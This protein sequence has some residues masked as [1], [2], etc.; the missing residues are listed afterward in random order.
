M[1]SCQPHIDPRPEKEVSET[2]GMSPICREPCLPA[3]KSTL[4]LVVL[5]CT[6]VFLFCT[7]VFYVLYIFFL[8]C[9]FV[10]L[11]CTFSFCFVHFLSVLYIFFLFCTICLYVLYIFFLFC[12]FAV[13]FCIFV[14]LFCTFVSSDLP[15]FFCQVTCSDLFFFRLVTLFNAW[16]QFWFWT[17]WMCDSNPKIKIFDHLIF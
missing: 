12:T 9:T 3:E 8:F 13:L 1:V 2:A 7:F 4:W 15:L 6:F 10:V 11:F 16:R 17:I 14:F 5:F